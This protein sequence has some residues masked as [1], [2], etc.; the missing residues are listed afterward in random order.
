MIRGAKNEKDSYRDCSALAGFATVAQ[1]LRKIT[2]GTL[3]LNWAGPSTMTLFH[4]Q[5]WPD[6]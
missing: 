5:Q 4:Q 2:P 3:V 6:P 1:P